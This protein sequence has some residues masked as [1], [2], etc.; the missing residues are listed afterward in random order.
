VARCKCHAAHRKQAVHDRLLSNDVRGTHNE[1]AHVVRRRGWLV[2]C[3]CVCVCVCT[4]SYVC[5]CV[6][7]CV[8][9]GGK[10]M[11]KTELAGAAREQIGQ[12]TDPRTSSRL[13][14]LSRCAADA[15]VIFRIRT[16]R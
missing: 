15:S 3:V 1:R 11:K 10:G 4:S 5:E 8:C 12:A 9:V 2:V 16:L 7:V 13:P 14:I 6:C